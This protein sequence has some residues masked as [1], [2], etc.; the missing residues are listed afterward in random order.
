MLAGSVIEVQL[1]MRALFTARSIRSWS[2]LSFVLVTEAT[3]AGAP[4]LFAETSTL[5]RR[6]AKKLAAAAYARDQ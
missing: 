1:R 5:F 2:I 4:L 3:A 6:C